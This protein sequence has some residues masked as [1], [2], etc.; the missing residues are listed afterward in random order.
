VGY[1]RVGHWSVC[2][3]FRLSLTCMDR[4]KRKQLVS[5]FQVPFAGTRN[6]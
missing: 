5:G 3:V 1:A 4:E 2:E 6:Q